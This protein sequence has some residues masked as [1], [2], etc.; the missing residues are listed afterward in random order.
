MKRILGISFFIICCSACYNTPKSN[1]ETDI[2][3][4]INCDTIFLSDIDSIIDGYVYG[5]RL[6]VLNHYINSILLEHQAQKENIPVEELKKKLGFEN[7]DISANKGLLNYLDSLKEGATIKIL[8][9]PNYFKIISDNN[10][11]SDIVQIGNSNKL[12]VFII[13][14]YKCPHCRMAKKQLDEIIKKNKDLSF[15]Y[16]YD[17]DYIDTAG[18][19]AHACGLQ[20][21]FLECYNWLFEG[22]NAFLE[23]NNML[24]FAFDLGLDMEQLEQDMSDDQLLKDYV[25]NK[26]KLYRAGIN[27]VPSF[28]VN[29]K[30]LINGSPIDYLQDVINHEKQN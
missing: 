5:L 24:Q 11:L 25:L 9:K 1:I 17:S 22:N 27:K 16:I 26:E 29:G 20:G 7:G 14:D 12:K 30:L 19:F 18:L 10:L 21:K 2:A 4:T 23:K 8:L 28:I 13:S 15:Y 3:A 6:G